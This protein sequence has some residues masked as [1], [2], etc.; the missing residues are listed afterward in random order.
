[1]PEA[2][3]SDSRRFVGSGLSKS[4]LTAA[5][6]RRSEIRH[7]IRVSAAVGVAFPLANLL[8]LPQGYWG[9]FTAVI[10]VQ[11]SIGVSVSTSIHRLNL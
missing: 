3:P 11:A 4:A 2:A 7:A 8:I 5:A 10:V 9:V 1:V 6:A